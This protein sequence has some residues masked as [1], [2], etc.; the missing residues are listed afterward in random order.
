MGKKGWWE[1]VSQDDY[2]ETQK[3][4]GQDMKALNGERLTKT[5]D[6]YVKTSLQEKCPECGKMFW[7]DKGC[8]FCK[9]SNSEKVAVKGFKKHCRSCGHSEVLDLKKSSS[10]LPFANPYNTS[11]L[12]FKKLSCSNCG[13]KDCFITDK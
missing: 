6:N 7:I 5:P 12:S 8:S 9:K 4:Y 2:P 1:Q 10:P 11:R 3:S 13:S